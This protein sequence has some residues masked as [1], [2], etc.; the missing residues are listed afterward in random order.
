MPAGAP[1]L[2]VAS[3]VTIGAKLYLR[4][5]L[6]IWTTWLQQKY[7]REV[8]Q[9]RGC[10]MSCYSTAINTSHESVRPPGRLLTSS[11]HDQAVVL[12]PGLPEISTH[13]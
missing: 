9:E 6:A 2:S 7:R 12:Q 11:A 4:R 10:R 8:S 5:Q 3:E 13:R 1:R